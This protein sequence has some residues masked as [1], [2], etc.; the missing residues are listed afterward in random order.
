MSFNRLT[1]QQ[2]IDYFLETTQTISY[3]Y[4][5]QLSATC[6][7]RMHIG[8]EM[9]SHN[10]FPMRP[11]CLTVR[12]M[13]VTHKSLRTHEYEIIWTHGDISVKKLGENF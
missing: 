3:A 12:R 6:S 11:Y 13:N 10:N 7:C 9:L 5:F 4:D 2:E 1:D 8:S